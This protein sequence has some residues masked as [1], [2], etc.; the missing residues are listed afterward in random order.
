MVYGLCAARDRG[1][2]VNN[3]DCS[4]M[5]IGLRHFLP[6]TQGTVAMIIS[7]AL[8][9]PMLLA[10]SPSQITLPDAAYS[11]VTQTQ[12]GGADTTSYTTYGG[13][14]TFMADGKPYDSDND[15]A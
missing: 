4:V 5:F 13:T 14:Q 6:T 1:E 11:H 7:V 12:T 8:L 9:T 10:S 2:R 3:P 15:S